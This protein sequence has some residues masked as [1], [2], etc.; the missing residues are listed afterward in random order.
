MS[1][2]DV[3]G[4][5][6][7]SLIKRKLRTFLTLLGVI[8]GTA[9]IILMMSLGMATEAQF[10]EMMEGMDAD[11]TVI[12]VSTARWG[13]PSPGGGWEVP[14]HFAEIDDFAIASFDQI[15]GVIVSSPIVQG[16]FYMRS[17]PYAAQTRW[18]VIGMRPEALALMGHRL[19]YGRFLGASNGMESIEAVFG[20]LAELNFYVPGSDEIRAWNIWGLDLDNIEPLVD[21]INDPIQISYDHR[22]APSPWDMSMW[23]MDMDDSMFDIEEVFRPISTFDLNVVGVLERSANMWDDTRIYVTIDVLMEMNWL[24]EESQ[25]EDQQEWGWFSPI[26][27]ER[28]RTTFDNAFVRV[29]SIDDTHRVAEII[30][31]MGFMASYPGE[32]INTQRRQQQN[33]RTLLTAI[34]GISLLVATINIA[35]TMITSVT[36]RTKEIGVMKVIGASIRD[37]RRMFLLE[38][39][40]IGIIGGI[41]GIAVSLIGSYVMN[42][43][44]VPFLEGLGPPDMSGWWG[45]PQAPEDAIVS[46]ITPWLLLLALG[47]AAG[48]GLIAGYFP[49]RRATKL[50]A[51]AAI[52]TD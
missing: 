40:M 46:L 19:A 30:E 47:V 6:V 22:I 33:L 14:D 10:A 4:L 49:A 37:I 8:I 16:G 12:N 2:F 21:V 29:A 34:A 28:E 44:D 3:F 32:F 41:F 24:A 11:M 39:V 45:M 35:N 31:E 27:G 38:A 18:D 50:S 5:C 26:R 20:G 52:R 43:F 48:V 15:P 36:E 13:R 25:R 42:N 7:R 9:S 17:G 1:S 51:L 23:G